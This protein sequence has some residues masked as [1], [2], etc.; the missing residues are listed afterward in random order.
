[1]I[2]EEKREGEE[3]E[4]GKVEKRERSEGDMRESEWVKRE[5]L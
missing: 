1:M 5:R 4:R 2:G 3:K